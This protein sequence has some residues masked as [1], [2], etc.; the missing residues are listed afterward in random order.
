MHLDATHSAGSILESTFSL[1]E[2]DC[3]DGQ[4]NEREVEELVSVALVT[5]HSSL[6][7]RALGLY[8]GLGSLVPLPEPASLARDYPPISELSLEEFIERSVLPAHRR[9]AIEGRFEAAVCAAT[10]SQERQ[11]V[12]ETLAIMRDFDG[13]WLAA[14]EH[15]FPSYRRM[16]PLMVMAVEL[17][18]EGAIDEAAC[19]YAMLV[20]RFDS[21]DMRMRIALGWSGFRPWRSYPYMEW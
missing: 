7:E 14:H 17:Y 20:E 8:W 11:E 10:S 1:L 21:P 18:R 3:V 2:R 16:G 6:A 12:A 5:G 15:V 9:L 4:V 13:A 19:I